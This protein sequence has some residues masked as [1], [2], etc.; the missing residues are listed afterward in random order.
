MASQKPIH[1]I[2]FGRIKVAIW[3]NQSQNG[4]W[5]SVQV[6]RVYCVNKDGRKELILILLKN[7]SVLLYLL[8]IQSFMLFF[9]KIPLVQKMLKL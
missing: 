8:K 1:V 4:P 7:L 9:Q 2:R 5:H 3:E 6:C